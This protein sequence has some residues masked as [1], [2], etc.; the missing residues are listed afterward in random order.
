[1]RNQL[2][3]IIPWRLADN[4]KLDPRIFPY[5]THPI[6]GTHN[7]LLELTLCTQN[8]GSASLSLILLSEVSLHYNKKKYKELCAIC[9]I[10]DGHSEWVL[11]TRY[12]YIIP[13][14]NIVKRK[15][16]SG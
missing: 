6:A 7:C 10:E 1:M 9:N 12:A 13:R 5:F 14:T 16:L 3:P 8:T 2:Y 15:A 11:W 4:S